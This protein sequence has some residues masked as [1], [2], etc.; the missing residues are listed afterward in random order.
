VVESVVITNCEKEKAKI[1]CEKD[2]LKEKLDKEIDLHKKWLIS[3]DNL[4][5]HLYGSQAINSGIGLGFKK[6]VGLE[7]RNDNGKST[8][9]GLAS[10]VKEGEMHKVPGPIRGV[11][12][13]TT[14]TS[15]FDGSHH[16]FGKK[17]TDLPSPSKTTIRTSKTT[18]HK[19]D[20]P[21]S[22]ETTGIRINDSPDS[23][24]I[25]SNDSNTYV[26]CS[27]RDMASETSSYANCES[28]TQSATPKSSIKSS[29]KSSYKSVDSEVAADE[30]ISK[31]ASSEDLLFTSVKNN[32]FQY[33][34][35]NSISGVS[36][37]DSVFNKTS[38]GFIKSF[39]KK[40]C[41]VCGSKFHLIKDCDFH[42]KRMG[43]SDVCDRPRPKWTNPS[44]K[45]SLVPQANCHISRMNRDPASGSVYADRSFSYNRYMH[46]H[47][48]KYRSKPF[49]GFNQRYG[50]NDP[51]FLGRDNWDSAE[52]SSADCSWIYQRPYSYRVSRNNC[53]SNSYS[54][55]HNHDSQGRLKS[56]MT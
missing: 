56:F 33:L 16:L 47:R 12:M 15:D 40:K 44:S 43:V 8:P 30:V 14:K 51:M 23:R 46:T 28:K 20:L 29:D 17:S 11:F 36:L 24:S 22:M 32:S 54:W 25:S 10:Y 21:D 52:K 41:F 9:A 55:V 1:R 3:G 42:D 6:Y 39:K 48:Y 7:A 31:I 37:N 19:L 27:S 2:V 50:Y 53:G 13:P 26:S 5:S 18:S 38:F 34:Q 35:N 4:A 49:N 45:P